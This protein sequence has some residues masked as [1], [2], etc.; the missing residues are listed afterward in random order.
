MSLKLI[1]GSIKFQIKFQQALLCCTYSRREENQ[2]DLLYPIPMLSIK[3]IFTMK[4]RHDNKL[5]KRTNYK[6]QKL[7]LTRME[8]RFKIE[9]SL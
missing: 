4:Y 2:R 1:Y 9:T 3:L 5:T 7:I 6:S 8:N